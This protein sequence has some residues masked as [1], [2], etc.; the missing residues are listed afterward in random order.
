MEYQKCDKALCIPQG[1]SFV[2]NWEYV[3]GQGANESLKNNEIIPVRKR[4]E[5][6]KRQYLKR[7]ISH[8]S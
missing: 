6:K 1:K 4:E 3:A 7:L 2:E 8:F 5:K